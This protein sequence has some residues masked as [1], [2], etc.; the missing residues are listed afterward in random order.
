MAFDLL[1]MIVLGCV[2]EALCVKFG[3]ELFNAVPTATFSLLITFL[4][5]TRW[6]L[7]GLIVCPFLALAT[8]YGGSLI[9]IREFQAAY[10]WELGVAVFVGL[11]TVGINVLFFRNGKTAKIINS[12]W[13]MAI[14]ILNYILFIMIQTLVYRLLTSGS[15]F[16]MAT[17]MYSYT[18]VT[19]ENIEKLISVNLCGYIENTFIYDLFGLAVLYIGIY[20]LRS[21]G[22]L[23][24]AIE[25]LIDDKKNAELDRVDMN[26]TI[27]EEK[28][29][30]SVGEN[31]SSDE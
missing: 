7:W 12:T 10:T 24:N 28:D 19:S 11:L 2:L 31:Q 26:F 25:R 22:V 13:L 4:A 6:N 20:I 29:D 3:S 16:H 9:Q 18:Y 14:P 17:R 30:D 15:L 8:Y 21:Q 23:C 27:S 1:T 5:V